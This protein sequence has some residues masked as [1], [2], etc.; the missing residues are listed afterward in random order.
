MKVCQKRQ[1]KYEAQAEFVNVCR[2]LEA[3][4]ILH[5]K[6]GKETRLCKVTLAVQECDVESALQDKTLLSTVLQIQL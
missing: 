2:M 3:R 4:G 1:V 6:S 5:I